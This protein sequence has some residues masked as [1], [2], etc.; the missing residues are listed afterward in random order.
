[1]VLKN[2]GVETLIIPGRNEMD[3]MYCESYEMKKESMDGES[4]EINGVWTPCEPPP[5]NDRFHTFIVWQN[6]LVAKR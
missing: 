6:R 1:M 4:Y 3:E 5:D 2:E